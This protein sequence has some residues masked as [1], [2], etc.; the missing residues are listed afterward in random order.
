MAGT[1]A[2]QWTIRCGVCEASQKL[3][4]AHGTR[5]AAMRAANG[6]GWHHRIKRG[7][8]CPDCW[9]RGDNMLITCDLIDLADMLDAARAAL[10][11]PPRADDRLRELR[12]YICAHCADKDKHGRSTRCNFC[13]IRAKNA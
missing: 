5:F 7:W 12:E 6:L 13:K 3:P 9:Q 2:A 10:R 11:S 4:D 8:V 1:I